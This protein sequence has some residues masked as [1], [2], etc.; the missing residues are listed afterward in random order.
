MYAHK[1]RRNYFYCG[2]PAEKRLT[3]FNLPPI[4]SFVKS[5]EGKEYPFPSVWQRAA[6]LVKGPRRSAAKWSRSREAEFDVSPAV[7]RVKGSSVPS[8]KF[9]WYHGYVS[10]PSCW[11]GAVF[12]PP[13]LSSS[14]ASP[15]AA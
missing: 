12:Y 5:F 4:L 10:A 2:G 7:P 14:R 15:S 13:T 1:E 3:N 6:R 9:G 8:G 11:L